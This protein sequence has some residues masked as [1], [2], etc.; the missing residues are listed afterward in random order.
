MFNKPSL[1]DVA[2]V[3]YKVSL[4]NSNLRLQFFPDKPSVAESYDK[5]KLSLSAIV[6]RCR[7]SVITPNETYPVVRRT[8]RGN[9]PYDASNHPRSSLNQ[10][11]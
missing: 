11:D 8:V 6:S 7:G 5:M 3:P 4:T 1:Q 2:S 9:V 10:I